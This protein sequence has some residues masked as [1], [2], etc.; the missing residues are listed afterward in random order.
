[1]PEFAVIL[2]TYNE[3]GNIEKVVESVA[4]VMQGVD[5][6][7]WI[8]DDNSPD[9]TYEKA[10][11]LSEKFPVHLI[12]RPKKMG[13]ASAVITGFLSSNAE[14]LICLDSDGQHD[15]GILPVMI[16]MFGKGADIIIG[17]RFL[18]DVSDEW[19]QRRNIISKVATALALPFTSIKDPMSGCFAVKREVIEGIDEWH[20]IGYK[21]L[22]EIL[23]KAPDAVV[24][25]VPIHFGVRSYG[26]SKLGWMEI[27]RYL[28]L[29]VNLGAYKLARQLNR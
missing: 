10:I 8:V 21:I 4:E 1:M 6:A 22:L 14:K 20:M 13:L 18:G 17:S 19:G 12:R 25:E 11:N 15:A 3:R 23:V 26:Q 24:Y 2:P 9:K 5:Y 28:L 29:L 27:W 7:I 16:N